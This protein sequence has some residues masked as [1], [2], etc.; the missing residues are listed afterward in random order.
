MEINWKEIINVKTASAMLGMSS[1]AFYNWIKKGKISAIEH[2]ITKR[3]LV[4][5]KDI[6]AIVAQIQALKDK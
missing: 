6:E 3:K 1:A 4:K 2:P 5:L